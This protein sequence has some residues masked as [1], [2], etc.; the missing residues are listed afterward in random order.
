MWVF[1]GAVV[2]G[3]F[4]IGIYAQDLTLIVSSGAVA[5]A[6]INA[7]QT[8]NIAA[9]YLGPGLF[10]MALV[11][12]NVVAQVWRCPYLAPRISMIGAAEMAAAYPLPNPAV[13]VSITSSF[14]PIFG[15]TP[16]PRTV[17]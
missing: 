2:N 6:G 1:N 12:D 7:R 5:Q 8:V 11:F 14:L 15:F 17:I 9:T 16:Y 4:D 10:Y 13:L 3:N